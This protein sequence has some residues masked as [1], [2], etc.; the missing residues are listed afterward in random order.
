MKPIS[1]LRVKCLTGYRMSVE[2]SDGLVAE[3][4]WSDRLGRAIPGGIFEPLK[5]RE[6]FACVELWPEARTI[7]WPN[8]ADICPDSLYSWAKEKSLQESA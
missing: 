8:G 2:F 3:I 4:D 6:L 1:V 5:D 7:R